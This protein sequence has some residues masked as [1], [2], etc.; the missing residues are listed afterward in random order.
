MAV[1]KKP[2]ILTK[3]EDKSSERKTNSNGSGLLEDNTTV[4]LTASLRSYH[5][6]NS[7]INNIPD[8]KESVPE[9]TESE[10]EDEEY[11]SEENEEIQAKYDYN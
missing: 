10:E 6:K 8:L 9:E 11:V 3:I 1:E 2:E 7:A 4:T 5:E